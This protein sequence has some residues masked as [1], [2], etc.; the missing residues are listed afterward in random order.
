MVPEELVSE[1]GVFMSCPHSRQN[2]KQKWTNVCVVTGLKEQKSK[3]YLQG[4]FYNNA[5]PIH[6]DEVI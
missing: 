3:A 6:E 1:E 2:R 5:N 4:F